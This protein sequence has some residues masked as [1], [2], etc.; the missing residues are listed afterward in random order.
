MNERGDKG[1][2]LPKANSKRVY[3][4]P[5][6]SLRA[7]ID[8]KCKECI[9]DP[10]SGCGTWREQVEACSSPDCPLFPHRPVSRGIGGKRAEKRA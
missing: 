3:K 8:A 10:L 9:Y 2:F 6:K 5:G 4:K 7:A 1:Y